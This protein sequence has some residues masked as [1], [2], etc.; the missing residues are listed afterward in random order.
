MK[1]LPEHASDRADGEAVALARGWKDM[2]GADYVKDVTCREPYVW[3]RTTR[4]HFNPP[5]VPVG[6]A[7]GSASPPRGSSGWPRST[8]APSETSTASSCSTG[9]RSTCSRPRPPPRRS[10]STARLRLPVER[11]GRPGRPPLHPQDR[12]G[13][14]A[15]FPDVRDL[16]R[17]P[18]DHACARRLDLQ[19]QVRPPRGQPAGQERRDGPGVDHGPEPRLR[20][21]PGERRQPRRDRDGVQPERQHGR[22]ASA[23]RSSRLLRAVPSGGAPGPSDADPLFVD[24]YR[25]VE[26][27]MAGK[28]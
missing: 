12:D 21:R 27:R 15:E 7:F 5:Y 1:M 24:F 6:T 14:P 2:A 13:A 16:P 28:V 18:D 10:R 3:R 11:P 25:M 4:R 20:D 23:T 9:S 22:G 17:P 19:A 8:T 26:S